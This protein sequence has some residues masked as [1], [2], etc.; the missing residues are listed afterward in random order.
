MYGASFL[1]ITGSV[2]QSD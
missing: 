2:W 1:I